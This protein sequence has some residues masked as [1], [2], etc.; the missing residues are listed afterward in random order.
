MSAASITRNL[1]DTLEYVVKPRITNK[2]A[3][4]INP[5][6]PDI[7]IGERVRIGPDCLRDGLNALFPPTITFPRRVTVN[8]NRFRRLTAQRAR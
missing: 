3:K 5:A 6:L 1:P 4:P 7:L 8:L 2:M